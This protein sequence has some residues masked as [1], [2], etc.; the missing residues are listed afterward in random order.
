MIVSQTAQSVVRDAL[1]VAGLASMQAPDNGFLNE[2]GLRLLDLLLAELSHVHHLQFMRRVSAKIDL[3]A[4]RA[5]YQNSDDETFP[6]ADYQLI[7]RAF[8]R[9]GKNDT[10]LEIMTAEK[11]DCVSD[12]SAPGKPSAI[13]VE[14]QANDV[15]L[16]VWPVPATD[17]IDL[18][19]S[20]V[21]YPGLG[22]SSLGTGTV[23]IPA[24]WQMFVTYALAIRAGD[25]LG[26]DK[27]LSIANQAK[28]DRLLIDIL[29]SSHR[30]EG[31]NRM[32]KGFDF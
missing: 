6:A 19:L 18:Y 24:G 8:L 31:N 12:K 16:H 25:F 10:C 26:G 22:A 11:W 21:T 1:V 3:E 30:Y 28:A 2:Q 9:E 14:R 17:D 7:E 23:S 15:I 32:V 20:G 5:S 29:K 4:D 13:F 27:N